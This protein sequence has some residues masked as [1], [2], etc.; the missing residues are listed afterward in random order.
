VVFERQGKLAEAE[1]AYREA[2]RLNKNL[3][4]TRDNL[5]WVLQRQGKFAD[6]EATYRETLRLEPEDAG[7]HNGLAWLRATCADPKFRNPEEAVALAERAV[8]LDPENAG[9]WNTLGVARYRAGDWRAAIAALEKSMALQQGGDAFDWLFLAMAHGQ[10]G[11]QDRARAWYDKAVAWMEEHPSRDPEE[12]SRFR[13]EA[14]DLLG[15]KAK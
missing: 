10:L 14:E 11:D 15:R 3:T 1:A 5:G 4:D 13:A 8:K 2:L 9:Y 12:L 7:A 6:A